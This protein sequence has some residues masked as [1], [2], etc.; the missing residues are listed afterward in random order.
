MSDD[1]SFKIEGPL[2]TLTFTRP[3]KANAFHPRM[4]AEMRRC[5][6][7]IQHN[8]DVRC[9]LI[10]GEGKHFMA[11]GD[12][13]V[14]VNFDN[15]S[16]VER[17]DVGEGVIH[18]YNV[19]VRTMQRLD[20]PVIA[21]IQGG[22]AGAAVGFMGACDLVIAADTSF[23]WIAHVLHGGSIDGLT[24][25]FTPRHIGLRKAM[26][27]ALLADRISGTQAADLGL[28]NFVVPEADLA[29]ETDKLVERLC[30]GPTQGYA[31]IKKLLYASF[32]NSMMEQGRM[33]AE[34]YGEILHTRDVQHGLK[35]FFDRK[36]PEFLGK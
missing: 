15:V 4:A 12:L 32:G 5:F 9:L 10:K 29:A 13:E 36:K 25:F 16:D 24:T 34:S 7:E 27:L 14:V 1:L 11:G 8:P 33:E 17:S 22:V 6:L 19:M 23:F 3:D 21:S 2:A 31:K 26:E 35:A 28:I 20:V 30:K 18:E